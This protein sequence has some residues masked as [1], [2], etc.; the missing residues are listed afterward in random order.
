MNSSKAFLV[1]T[2]DMF[3]KMKVEFVD[4]KNDSKSSRHAINFVLTAHHLK[5]WVWKAYLEGN[6][7]LRATI[8]PLAH[9]KK[10]YY[11]YLNSECEEI[12]LI[13]ALANN[14]KHFYASESESDDV[15]E[16]TNG[17]KT[18]EEMTCTLENCHIP[19]G[20]E[21]II[22]ITKKNNWVSALDVFQKAH[23]YWVNCFNTLLKSSF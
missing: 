18:L 3:E 16:T 12:K 10:N 20:Y 11:S 1:T 21:G 4:F 2:R 7:T 19:L 8:S 15:Q 17:N 13:H 9:D 6:K 22:I 14:I 23:D 5:E